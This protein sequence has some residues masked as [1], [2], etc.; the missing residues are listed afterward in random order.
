MTAMASPLTNIS[1]LDGPQTELPE[2]YSL[3]ERIIEAA[4]LSVIFVVA[5]SGNTMLWMV[6]F[7]RKSLRTTS[8]ALILCL[9]SADLLVSLIN[10]PVTIYTIL[11][12]VWVF[13]G[14]LCTFFGFLNMVTFIGSVMSLAAISINRYILIVHPNKFRKAYTKRNTALNILGVWLL[15]FALASPPLLGWASYGYLEG[16]SFCFCKWTDDVAYTFFMVGVCFG[17]PCSVMSYCYTK[18]LLAFKNSQRNISQNSMANRRGSIGSAKD[19]CIVRLRNKIEPNHNRRKSLPN[20]AKSDDQTISTGVECGC[21]GNDSR[22]RLATTGMIRKNRPITSFQPLATQGTKAVSSNANNAISSSSGS[23]SSS[24]KSRENTPEPVSPTF[25]KNVQTQSSMKLKSKKW[26]SPF[27]KSKANKMASEADGGA[28]TIQTDIVSTDDFSNPFANS[29]SVMD[30][31]ASAVVT[32]TGQRSVPIGLYGTPNG[33]SSSR[34][35]RKKKR[36]EEEMRLTKSFIVVIF[37]F[38]LCWFPFCITMFWSVFIRDERKS[39]P[40]VIDM[41][42]LLL[43]FANSCCNPIIYGV[44]NRKFRAGFRSLLCWWK[45]HNVVKPWKPPDAM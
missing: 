4:I 42:T 25:S 21:Y 5:V 24:H 45:D 38:I 9:S 33:P 18:I 43:G 17:G 22:T 19:N 16:Q 6:I 31:G 34:I 12:G 32:G 35:A 3:T 30:L 14:A 20:I 40:R 7:R 10:M 15:S 27:R 44:M 13:S 23:L 26:K 39:V 29:V 28:S 41:A 36:R 37:V 8:N 11:K 1:S 2:N